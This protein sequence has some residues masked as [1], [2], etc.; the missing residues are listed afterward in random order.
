MKEGNL[1]ECLGES[2]FSVGLDLWG[3]CS[4]ISLSEVIINTGLGQVMHAKACAQEC[5]MTDT[6]TVRY[7]KN[8]KS[9][10]IQAN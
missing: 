10:M 3:K 1:N 6:C 2:H 4:R 5:L 9:V 8:L 7:L